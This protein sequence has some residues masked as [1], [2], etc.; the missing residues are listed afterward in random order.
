MDSTRLLL[1]LHPPFRSRHSHPPQW[2]RRDKPWC[3]LACGPIVPVEAPASANKIMLR[4]G[5]HDMTFWRPPWHFNGQ[6]TQSHCFFVRVLQK[7]WQQMCWY[8]SLYEN[9]LC[10]AV[11]MHVASSSWPVH[12]APQVRSAGEAFVSLHEGTGASPSASKG[13]GSLMPSLKV[14]ETKWC[15]F[16]SALK[17]LGSALDSAERFMGRTLGSN[18]LRAT[19][20]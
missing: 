10:P 13:I 6:I 16:L 8:S 12:W 7:T 19:V 14:R 1:W 20:I 11:R 18:D 3:F 5:Y 9:L 15:D 2:I 17:R 4:Q